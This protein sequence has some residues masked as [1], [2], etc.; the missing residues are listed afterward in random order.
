MIVQDWH[1]I[2]KPWHPFLNE[3][4]GKYILINYRNLQPYN[5]H[6]CNKI[7]VYIFTLSDIVTGNTVNIELN[8]ILQLE[9]WCKTK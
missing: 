7:P 4:F 5:P 9:E 1:A 8:N 2:S 6:D 3:K